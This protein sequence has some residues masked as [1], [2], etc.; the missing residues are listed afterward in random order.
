MQDV[1]VIDGKYYTVP[2]EKQEIPRETIE[3]W[4]TTAQQNLAN[5]QAGKETQVAA[6]DSMI[7]NCN[8]EIAAIQAMLDEIPG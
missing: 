5:A 4:L 2:P 6:L 7:N 3:G 8:T 1:Q